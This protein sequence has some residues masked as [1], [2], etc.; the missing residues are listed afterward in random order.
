LADLLP[1]ATTLFDLAALAASLSLGLYIVTRSP[2][3][4]VS[5]LAALTL[6]CLALFF[7]H[8][9][10]AINMP[11]S[12]LLPWVQPVML[13]VPALWL[14]LTLELV[15]ARA[16]QQGRSRSSGAAARR[17]AVALVYAAALALLL[18]NA[19]WFRDHAGPITSGA[20]HVAARASDPLY[21]VTTAFVLVV[22]GLALAN[23]WQ[24]YRY[25]T[26][27]VRRRQ[28]R[29][30]FIATVLAALGSLYVTVGIVL[31]VDLPELPRDV[32]YGVAVALLGFA[33]ARHNALVE[34]RV[35]EADLRYVLLTVGLLTAGAVLLAELLYS[36]GHVYSFLTLTLVMAATISVLMLYDG[37]R[38]AL[39]RLFYR[40]QFRQLRANLRS[41]ASEAGTGLSLPEQLETILAWLRTA[42][43]VE[44]GLIALAGEG[45]NGGFVVLAS[46]GAAHVGQALP[47][48]RLLAAE[49][50][51]WKPD[52]G[53][54]AARDAAQEALAG[55]ALLAPL[56]IGGSQV[57][58]LLLGPKSTGQPYEDEDLMLLDDVV[59]QLAT[60]IRTA[61]LQEENARALNAM[62]SEFRQQERAMQRQ[63]QEMLAASSAA[64][65]PGPA[66]LSQQQFVSQVEEAL[67][68]LHDYPA[69]GEH[70]LAGLAI[71]SQNLATAGPEGANTHID[72]GKALNRVMVQAID[73]LR[74][75]GAAPGPHDIPAREWHQFIILHDSYVLD[76][77]NRDIMSRLYIGEG[78]FNRTRRRALQGVARALQEMEEAA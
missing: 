50:K 59:D 35:I 20:M 70:P 42:L 78:T 57:G 73:K 53:Q 13:L 9:A 56:A 7:F 39:D 14:H 54:A 45:G 26:S 22:A 4:R 75:D 62:V 60:I 3:S 10:L 76:E 52:G 47:K 69:L 74:P 72:R 44:H 46:Q 28:F 63:V 16:E 12:A 17:L 66:G 71:V 2:R 18:L 37:V 51:E 48:S 55:M 27:E 30:L 33:V 8:N 23:L 41:L 5:W 36:V 43:S 38:S 29:P 61:R 34:G 40:D 49:I 15:Q 21:P 32:M 24:G 77:P 65:Q 19:I 64:P 67:R 11:G 1:I 58:V 68:R 6:W 25:D 31:G